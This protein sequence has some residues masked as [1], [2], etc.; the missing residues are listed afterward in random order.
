M[1]RRAFTMHLKPGAR[2]EY[3][4]LHDSI[5]SHWAALVAQI[6]ASGIARMVIFASS[7]D[8]PQLFLFSEI[9]DEQAWARLWQS[10]IHQKWGVVMEPLMQ[11]TDGTVAATTLTEVFHLETSLAQASAPPQ[12]GASGTHAAQA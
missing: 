9:I 6:E 2:A 4:R 12:T 7:G 10:D 3:V 11:F 1:I 8:A 5:H